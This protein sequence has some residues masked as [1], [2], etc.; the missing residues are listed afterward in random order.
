VPQWPSHPA[1]A[2]YAPMLRET[3]ILSGTSYAS[4]DGERPASDFPQPDPVSL[5]TVARE[6]KK[7]HDQ[8]KKSRVV[9]INQ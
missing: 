5:G 3:S 7:E 8:V 4:A 9:W 1:Q 6:L 2:T